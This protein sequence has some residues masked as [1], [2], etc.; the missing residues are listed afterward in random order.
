MVPGSM[1]RGLAAAAV[2]AGLAGGPGLA[3]CGGAPVVRPL[4]AP[5][6]PALPGARWGVELLPPRRL[7]AGYL[8]QVR[9]HV[10]D[11]A[12]AAP[13]FAPGAPAQLA[14][15]AGGKALARAGA[16]PGDWPAAGEPPVAGRVYALSFDDTRNAVA[17]GERVT[18]RLGP[19][20]EPGL[21]VEEP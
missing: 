7:A 8:V 21:V 9:I 10:L 17:A 1:R 5:G 11:P 12:R 20:E 2:L 14:G 3:G 13:L 19:L 15:E 16:A 18:L 6:A 4:A